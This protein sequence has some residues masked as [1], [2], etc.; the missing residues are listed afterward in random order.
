MC[1]A[2]GECAR[3]EDGDGFREV[4]VDTMEGVWSLLRSWLP[5]YRGISQEKLPLHLAFFQLVHD[6]RCRGTALLGGL[7]AAL[8]A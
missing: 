8:V 6:A 7:V 2:R 4:H 1:H 5:P 3:D